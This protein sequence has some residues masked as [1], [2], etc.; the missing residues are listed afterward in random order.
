M[1]SAS[2]IPASIPE[3]A[4]E[5][6]RESIGGAISVANTLAA[7]SGQV[8]IDI[9]GASFMDG[10]QVIMF[11]ICALGLIGAVLAYRFMPSETR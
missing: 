10:W 9:A 11:V 5:I 8:L 4:L 3:C 7:E 6:A 2:S 1:E